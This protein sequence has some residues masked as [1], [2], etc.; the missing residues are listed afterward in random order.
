MEKLYDVDALR[1]ASMT[2]SFSDAEATVESIALTSTVGMTFSVAKLPMAIFIES[3]KL[4]LNLSG[5]DNIDDLD[6]VGNYE[7]EHPS[8]SSSKSLS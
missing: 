6:K 1:T 2:W 8:T 7:L 4:D 3:Y 5:Q